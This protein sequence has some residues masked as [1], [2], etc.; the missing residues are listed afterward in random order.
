MKKILISG[1]ILAMMSSVLVGCS[2]NSDINNLTSNEIASQLIDQGYVPMPMEIDEAM[3][4]EVYH[5]NLDNVEDYAVYETG[6]SP[7]VGLIVIA[8]AKEGKVEDVK[9]SM[10]QLLQD[11][12]GNAFYPEE[13]ETAEQATIEV[14][15]N[16]VS[17]FILNSDVDADAK[18]M[19]N[20][21]L[22]K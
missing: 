7:G 13:K 16:F 14:D 12:I 3:A 9:N 5:I 20:D 11:E 6:R 4:Q 18:K 2:S 19:Y 1:L 8:K 17:L 15:G 21:L 10:E 22:Q